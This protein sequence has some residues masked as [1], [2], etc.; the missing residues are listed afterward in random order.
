M[1]ESV[2]REEADTGLRAYAV[3]PGV[4]DTDMQEIIRNKT[5]ADFPEV[6]KFLELKASGSF[7]RPEFVARHILEL[8]FD[9]ERKAD[10][11]VIRLPPESA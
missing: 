11:V 2:Q 6:A 9:P 4:I 7:N 8:A 3:A 1:T 5:P 10:S